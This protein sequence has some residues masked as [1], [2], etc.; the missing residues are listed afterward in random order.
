MLVFSNVHLLTLCRR[1]FRWCDISVSQN[2]TEVGNFFVELGQRDM[3]RLNAGYLKFNMLRNIFMV[4]FFFFQQLKDSTMI[5]SVLQSFLDNKSESI[6]N[7]V[8]CYPTLNYTDEEGDKR[9]EIMNR[10]FLMYGQHPPGRTK[11][12]I[13]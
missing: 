4:I 7:L 3:K 2:M 10:Y 5:V 13:V 6:D 11:E 1:S 8:K 9:V 12:D